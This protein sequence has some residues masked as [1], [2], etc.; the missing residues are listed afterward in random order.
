MYREKQAHFRLYGSNGA[1][2]SGTPDLVVVSGMEGTVYDAKTGQPSLADAVQVMVYMWALPL[3]LPDFRGVTF[4]GTI[5]YPAQ[6][7]HI[8]ASAI[9]DKF[10]QSLKSLIRRLAATQPA[11]KVASRQECR[12]CDLTEADCPERTSFIAPRS[13][14]KAI[15][16]AF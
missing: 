8:P 14:D 7:S 6:R 12:F 13:D 16:L 3:A 2:L 11:A 1:V 4:A 10:K 5:V 15:E 9:D